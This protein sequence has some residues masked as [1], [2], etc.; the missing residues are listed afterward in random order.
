ML[1]CA[2]SKSSETS[3]LDFS[4]IVNPTH[5]V[6]LVENQNRKGPVTEQ[7]TAADLL[8]YESVAQRQI[9]E[10][11]NIRSPWR[12]GIALKRELW[13]LC[14]VDE[15]HFLTAKIVLISRKYIYYNGVNIS[16]HVLRYDAWL[17]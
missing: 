12:N 5:P 6:R 11:T 9:V 10:E 8:F 16:D 17:R 1:F 13:P 2:A 14:T 15:H 3:S 7:V 4:W